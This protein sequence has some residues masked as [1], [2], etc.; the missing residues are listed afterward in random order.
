MKQTGICPK[1]QTSGAIRVKSFAATSQS[2]II[3]LS[4]WGIQFATFDRY[5]CPAC[6][7]IEQ[8]VN[9]EEKGW[10]KWLEK[11]ADE[12]ALDSDFV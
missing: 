11:K 8:Y 9:L 4:K 10:Q 5:V 3:R 6:G 7:F 2:N 12:D 1:C